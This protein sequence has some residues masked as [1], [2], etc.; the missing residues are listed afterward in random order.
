[1]KLPTTIRDEAAEEAYQYFHQNVRPL[2]LVPD[3]KVD[4]TQEKL[5]DND[6]DAFRHAYVSGVFAQE[7]GESVADILGRL[8]ELS[9]GDLYSN[10]KDPRSRNMDLWNN[11]IGRKCGILAD[12]REA[13]LKGVHQALQRGELITELADPRR[14]EGAKNDPLNASKT[15]IV[16]KADANGR[17][18]I[19]YDLKKLR[20]MS[21]AEFVDQIRAGSYPGYAVKT[22]HGVATPVS[23][24][25]GRKTN[26]LT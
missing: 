25:D 3:G 5:N 24:P 9:P 19:F 2:R 26:N 10:T 4:T 14:F 18:E 11:S 16:L 21:C 20:I 6:V 13:L 22:I 17:N 8:N 23:N 15:V 1:M 7:Y 12:T